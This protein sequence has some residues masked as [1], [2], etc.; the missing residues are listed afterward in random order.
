MI[1]VFQAL[2]GEEYVVGDLAVINIRK[3]LWKFQ[4]RLVVLNQVGCYQFL[5]PSQVPSMTML[6]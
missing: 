6:S 1:P 3:L 4:P 2:H 5:S